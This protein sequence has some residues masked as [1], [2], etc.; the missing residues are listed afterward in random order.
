MHIQECY[1]SIEKQNRCRLYRNIKPNYK[2][3]SYLLNNYNKELRQCLTK[4]RM[5]SH[6]LLVERGR[7]QRPKLEYRDRL[8]TM[9]EE[10]DIED[11]YHVLMKCT[12]FSIIRK[13]YLRS[14]YSH[15]PSMFKFQKLLTTDN[16][17]DLFRLMLYIQ[18][19]LKMYNSGLTQ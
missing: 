2:M 19:V 8:C 7:W 18:I 3:E 9:C 13:K 5:C 11:E 12:Y 1:S 6:K 14:Y 16:K 17:R 15:R 4:I 10:R